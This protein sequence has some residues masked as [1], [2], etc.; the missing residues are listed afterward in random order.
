MVAL[1]NMK[2]TQI[3]QWKV[4]KIDQQ[5]NRL[6]WHVTRREFESTFDLWSSVQDPSRLASA[7]LHTVSDFNWFENRPHNPPNGFFFGLQNDAQIWNVSMCVFLV[8]IACERSVWKEQNCKL[9]KTMVQ[10]SNNSYQNKLFKVKGIAIVP[11]TIVPLLRCLNGLIETV[12]LVLPRL[13]QGR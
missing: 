2:S 10:Y 7:V 4:W 13:G 11:L 5:N 1:H 12:L 3:W 8:G 9:E 6:D